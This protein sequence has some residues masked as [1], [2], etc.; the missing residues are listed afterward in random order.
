MAKKKVS[1]LH[2]RHPQ[3]FDAAIEP[4][5]YDETSKLHNDLRDYCGWIVV[6]E[7][8]EVEFNDGSEI[9]Q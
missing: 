7:G 9:E 4:M 1:V 3:G 5:I 2:L 6:E 8:V